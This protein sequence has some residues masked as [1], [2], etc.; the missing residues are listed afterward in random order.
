MQITARRLTIDADATAASDKRA[1]SVIRSAAADS[2][3]ETLNAVVL[4]GS[5]N[6]ATATERYASLQRAAQRRCRA[7]DA[8][9][10]AQ[11]CRNA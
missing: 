1:I 2:K 3:Y 10:T 11:I 9:G 7:A 5:T 4:T 8:V 6:D